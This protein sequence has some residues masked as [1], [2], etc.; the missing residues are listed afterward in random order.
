MSRA[1]WLLLA[2]AAC[3][4]LTGCAPL[5]A[6]PYA[7]EIEDTVLLRTL[8]VDMATQRLD[9]VAVTDLVAYTYLKNAHEVGDALLLTVYRDLN[10]YDREPGEYVD[11]S[12]VLMDEAL[13]GDAT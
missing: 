10:L 3:A 6:L 11:I 1:Q 12:V 8:G 2:A 4:A 7:Y 5:D 9:G 13:L